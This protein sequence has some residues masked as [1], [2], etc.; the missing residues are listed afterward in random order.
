MRDPGGMISFGSRFMFKEEKLIIGVLRE[1][2]W[3]EKSMIEIA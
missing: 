3:L 2:V 1:E